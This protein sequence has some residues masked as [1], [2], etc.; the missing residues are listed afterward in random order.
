M[1]WLAGSLTDG[2]VE[3]PWR[4]YDGSE[5]WA[6]GSPVNALQQNLPHALSTE[7]K[8]TGLP[9]CRGLECLGPFRPR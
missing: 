7:M 2:L 5:I 8:F 9:D 3:T 4:A 1:A 6:E